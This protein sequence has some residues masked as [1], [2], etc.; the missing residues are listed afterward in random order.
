MG[1]T[2]SAASSPTSR[3]RR[4][5][6]RTAGRSWFRMPDGSITFDDLVR[7]EITFQTEF[8]PDFALC[9]AN[10]DPLYTLVAPVDDLLMEITHVL[11]GEDLLSSTP[12]Q[13]ALYDALAQIGVGNGSTP[14]VGHLPYVMGE[15]NKKLS[16]RDPQAHLLAYRDQGFLPEGLLNYLALLGWAIAADRDIFGLDE[17]VEAFD[18]KDV[19]PNPARF[20]LKKA[21]AINAAHMRL[22]TLEDMTGRVVPFL[23]QAGLV[24]DPV[25]D[26]QRG[27]LDAAMPLV[28]ERINKLTEAVDMLAFLLVD[29]ADFAVDPTDAEKLLTEDGLAV[30]R[31]AYD[32][33]SGLDEWTTDSIQTALQA[34]LVDELGPQAPQRLRPG[35][36]RRHR[37]PDLPPLFESLELLGR[38]RGLDRLRG[39]WR[40]PALSYRAWAP[41]GTSPAL[42]TTRCRRPA[43]AAGGAPWSGRS[44]SSCSC[45]SWSRCSSRSRSRSVR[46]LR[47]AHR[48]RHA[49]AARPRRPDAAGAGLPEPRARL[50][51]P[52][53]VAP[54]ARPA[55]PA[56]ALA[57]VG[58]GRHPVALAAGLLRAL[59]RVAAG[60]PP[61]VGAGPR[62]RRGRPGEHRG[63]RLH[64]DHP[65][66]PAGPGPAD[67]PAG[68]GEEYAFRGYLTQ[69]FG[70]LFRRPWV[71]VAGPALL[72]ALAHGAQDPPVFF[73]RFAFGVVAGVLVIAT[74]GLEAGIAMHV[75]NNWLAFGLALA[76]GDMGS[77]L[78]PTGGTWWSLP[79]TL[80]QSLVYLGLAIFV[81]RRMGLARAPA[82]RF[83]GPQSSRG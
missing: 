2:G 64:E 4:S 38:E 27:V 13:V 6:P 7:G 58:G 45:W 50:R 12:R 19:N 35:P 69:A 16:K 21:E 46:G 36:G 8:V 71:A 75:L 26:E 22:L 54:D 47:R 51:D 56:S 59:G 32:V 67:P 80:T 20:D 40:E 68:R 18:I 79:A 24:A 39:H 1:T 76:F 60:H 3:S 43:A 61:G 37:A 63:Q 14:R 11:R 34:K 41:A 25:T 23:Q 70:G 53:H 77:T 55:R 78:N 17:M 83:G 42:P 15:G 5:G 10:G 82:G 44:R 81:A 30:V 29:E 74:G 62:L 72:F 9:R 31:A 66:L 57:G 28:A 33:L 73:D 65:R 49:A 48:R 52:G